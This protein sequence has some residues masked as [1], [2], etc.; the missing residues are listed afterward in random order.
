M[1]SASPRTTCRASSACSRRRR[2]RRTA[3]EGLGI[4]LS[5]VSRLLEMHG[6]ELRAES[7]GIG[8][9]STFTAELPVLRTSRNDCADSEAQPET[10][11]A[12]GLRVLLVDD[13]V[14][15][16]EM[17][18]FLLAE[19]GHETWTTFDAGRI[20]AMALE[21]KPQVI[22]LDIGLPGADGYELARM[23]KQHPQLR[24]IRLVAHTG[25][26]SPEDRRRALEAG[27]DAHRSSR[28]SWKTWKRRC[29]ASAPGRPLL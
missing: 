2:C 18:G 1:A 21:H 6:G 17:M 20:E 24:H 7:P 23:L 16:M 26:G 12:A 3:P 13:N 9:G 25:Y 11:S 8:M 27:F 22:V 5:L 29:A 28:P 14:D 19:M 15:A 4:G 10:G